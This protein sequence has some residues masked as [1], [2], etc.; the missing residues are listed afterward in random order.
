MRYALRDPLFHEITTLGG[1]G[2]FRPPSVASYVAKARFPMLAR[3]AFVVTGGKSPRCPARL[4]AANERHE[5]LR[6]RKAHEPDAPQG[7]F[8]LLGYPATRAQN[9]H[10]PCRPLARTSKAQRRGA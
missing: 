4:S 6:T 10:R 1:L 7:S 9:R 8:R 5:M 2:M 3:S